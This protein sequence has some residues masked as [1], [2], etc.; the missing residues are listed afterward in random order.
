MKRLLLP[1]LAALALPTA[2]N[3]ELVYL[4]CYFPKQEGTKEKNVEVT[5]QEEQGKVT[6]LIRETGYTATYPAVFNS[7]NILFSEEY[8]GWE[9]NRTNGKIFLQFYTSKPV[10]GDCKKVE[11]TKTMF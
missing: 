10:S 9:I 1:L 5:L 8:L 6:T 4:E 2:V 7:Q 3:A 11:K